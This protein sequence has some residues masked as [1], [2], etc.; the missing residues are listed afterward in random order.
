NNNVL[1]KLLQSRQKVT[2][3]RMMLKVK[4]GMRLPVS[5]TLSPIKEV[6]GYDRE[7]NRL[8]GM[9]IVFNDISE[10]LSSEEKLYQN[11]EKYRK[12]V[13]LSPDIIAIHS[14]GKLLFANK[15]ARDTFGITSTM[16]KNGVHIVDIIPEEKNADVAKEAQRTKGNALFLPKKK[17]EE[18][19]VK[20]HNNKTVALEVSGVPITYN[21]KPAV[22]I[23]ARN[24]TSRKAYEKTIHELAYFDQL[25]GLS[26]RIMFRSN[27]EQIMNARREVSFG[28]VFIDL[29]D[30]KRINDTLGHSI[31]DNLLQL[32]S[33]R[34]LELVG[35]G[36]LLSRFGGDEF[37]LV[38]E[39]VSS[40]KK[41]RS[42]VEKINQVISQPYEILN[43]EIFLNASIGVAVY[44]EDSKNLDKLIMFAEIAMYQAKKQAGGGYMLYTK[45]IN[46]RSLERLQLEGALRRS[47]KKSEFEL[48]YQPKLSL[49]NNQVVGMEAL[50]RWKRPGYPMMSPNT[51]IPIAEDMGLIPKI[52][53][54]V[55]YEAC[56]QNKAWQDEGRKPLR[57]AVNLSLFDFKVNLVSF[58]R[59]ALRE[60]KMDPQ[61]LEL[62]LTESLMMENYNS[63]IGVLYQL[64][65]L[66]VNVTIDDF[67]TGY[68][69]LSRLQKLPIDILK[70]DKS[71]VTNIPREPDQLAIVS[72]II[73]ISKSLKL[74]IIA[75]G[76]EEPEQFSLLKRYGCDE[77]QG[78][79]VS[80]PVAKEQF[81]EAIRKYL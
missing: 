54:W 22:Q 30:F 19:E 42:F 7:G 33:M 65:D 61:Y 52:D 8:T 43:Y 71:F 37:V 11:E 60:T 36:D 40:E 70:I 35:D 32:V 69:S 34:L 14:R 64:K 77:I 63:I 23:F 15:A 73:G 72:A 31:G 39:N 56:R 29:D 75:E 26:N 4:D 10:Y 38:V 16:I 50:V 5:I 9:V 59:N 12:L 53:E 46:V 44:P 2:R 80:P 27:L 81:F 68:S 51:F 55:V 66:G 74:Q 13:E 62:E 48:H 6:S 25:T 21:N 67:G 47:I 78:F 79:Y 18:V 1:P 28:L 41:L 45:E 76:V 3:R 17:M 49:K 24:I 20:L 57:V 58:I